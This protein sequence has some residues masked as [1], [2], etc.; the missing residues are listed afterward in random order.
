[1]TYISK[2]SLSSISE[3]YPT[4]R[5]GHRGAVGSLNLGRHSISCECPLCVL[6]HRHDL[7]RRA[8]PPMKYVQGEVLGRRMCCVGCCHHIKC[9]GIVA[10]CYR[11]FDQRSTDRSEVT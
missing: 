10:Q 2:A 5:E 7:L 4:S 9:C 3:M 1:M 11:G 8:E 6:R